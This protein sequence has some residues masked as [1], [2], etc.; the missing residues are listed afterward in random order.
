MTPAL[1]RTINVP[2]TPRCQPCNP[3]QRSA[4]YSAGVLLDTF[5]L[6]VDVSAQ[7]LTKNAT[8]QNITTSLI[9][10]SAAATLLAVTPGLDTV[11]VLRAGASEGSK[12]ALLAA[13][14]IVCGC[15]AWAIAVAGGLGVVLV[16]SQLAYS[17]LRWVG[18]GYLIYLGIQLLRHPRSS[19]LGEIQQQQRGQGAF[20]RGA[21]TNLLNPKVGIFYVSFLPQFVPR[22]VA[23]APY[24]L[25]LGGIHGLVSLIWFLC[26][27]A[28]MRPLLRWLRRP[29]VIR[30]LDRATGAVFLLFGLRLAI[31]SRRA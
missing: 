16:A 19:F 29:S 21:L 26:L 23:V 6:G 17:V 28:A 7:A 20:A 31:E 8:M 5:A 2:S 4:S 10:Y 13:L 11:L 14:G 3:S 27:I 12:H 25:L 9:A 22:D 24:T 1:S 15:F 30:A 18:A